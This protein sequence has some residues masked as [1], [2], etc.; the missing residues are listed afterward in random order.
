MTKLLQ[1]NVT[2]NWGSHGTIA[3][4]I[5]ELAQQELGWESYI[6]YGRRARTSSSHLIHIGNM[7]DERWHGVETRLFD[8]AGLASRLT[9]KKF[10]R[11]LDEIKPDII[12]LHNLTGYYINYPLLFQYIA[13]HDIPTVWTLH[14]CWFM[15]GHCVHFE[16][17]NCDRWKTGC[18]R[19]PNIK[20]YPES[21]G[22]DNSKR[23]YRLKKHYFN[24]PGKL[25][26]VPVSDWL[27][28]LTRLSFLKDRNIVTIHNGI[29]LTQF[30]PSSVRKIDS[31]K[32]IVLGVASKWTPE[33][34]MYDVINLCNH[35]EFQVVIIGLDEKQCKNLPDNI[36]SI[37]R[38]SSQTELACYYS[39]AN[40]FVNP[41][42]SD[43]F[44]TVNIEALACGTPVVTYRTGGSPESLT[45]ETGRVVEQGDQD[46]LY[47]A[48]MEILSLSPE[49]R[50][51]MKAA[52]INRAHEFDYH[53][54][55]KD[56]LTLY[57]SMLKIE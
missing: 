22:I 10:L 13:D 34:G 35:A 16:Y 14:D 52:C 39:N 29:D 31:D 23:N 33:R 43:N 25:T 46:A 5:G 21:L 6:A 49:K 27:N 30:K 8:N 41:T 17:I 4:K 20:S 12:H 18:G 2:A 38:T 11:L 57:K 54:R 56:Y 42:Y 44:P 24:L 28:R 53:V 50:A 9:T 51:L 36:I 55:F 40:V 37:P 26:L 3:E 48:I 19:C 7:W 47:H 1:I 15:T 32:P 45:P